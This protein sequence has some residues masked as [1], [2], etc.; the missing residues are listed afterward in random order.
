MR[1]WGVKVSPERTRLCELGYHAHNMS[2]PFEEVRLR[3]VGKRFGRH[4]ALVDVSAEFRAGQPTL[5]M[6]ANGAGKSTLLHL[7]STLAR[8]SAG[9]I[10]FGEYDWALARHALRQEIGLLGHELMLYADLSL[11]ENLHFLARLYGLADAG[12]Q[13]EKQIARF[14]LNEA[15]DRPLREFSRGMKQRAA[16]AR[17]TLHE[18]K[19]L[20]FDEPFSG[21]DAAASQSVQR[22]LTTLRDQ[23]AI[24]IIVSHTAGYLDG[25]CDQLLVLKQ[26]RVVSALQQFKM[27][28]EAIT[29]HYEAQQR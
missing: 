23:G 29:A 6:G 4:I 26:G 17:A 11:R 16:L 15:A 8:P 9:T 28:A 10:Q 20:L 25:L 27:R 24:V 12:V 22:H 18:P 14:E 1:A 2:A 7:L 13:I 19:L 3:H 5:L 21:L